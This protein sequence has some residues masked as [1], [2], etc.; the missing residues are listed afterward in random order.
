MRRDNDLTKRGKNTNVTGLAAP[1]TTDNGEQIRI[2]DNI[3]EIIDSK[4][5]NNIAG[6]IISKSHTQEAW[7]LIVL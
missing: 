3:W 1:H 7:K 2:T 6:Y 4:A 5:G